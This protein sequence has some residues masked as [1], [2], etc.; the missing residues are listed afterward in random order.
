VLISRWVA[1]A[2]FVLA[3][4]VFLLLA[5]VRIAGSEPRVYG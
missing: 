2:L 3:V 4:P 5:N 1:T